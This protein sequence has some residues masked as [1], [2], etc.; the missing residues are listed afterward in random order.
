MGTYSKS[1]PWSFE[2]AG[3]DVKNILKVRSG[4]PKN[5]VNFFEKQPENPES[6]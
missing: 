5:S 4:K 2:T 3:K 6:V 1:F